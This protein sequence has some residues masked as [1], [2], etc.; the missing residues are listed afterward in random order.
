MVK[1]DN[2]NLELRVADEALAPPLEQSEAAHFPEWLLVLAKRKFFIFKFVAAGALLSVTVS[3]LLTPVY[4]ATTKVMPPQQNQSLSVTAMM[5]QLGPLAALAGQGLGVRTPSDIYVA[6]LK[7]DTVADSL[8]DRFSLMK[9]YRN[10]LRVDTRKRLAGNSLIT[11]GKEGVISIAVDDKDP[12][13]AAE[14]ANGYVDELSKLSRTLAVT[15]AAQRRVF[16][17]RETKAAMDDL[18]N[19]ELGL[20]Q[21]Q[22]KTGLILL[23]AQSRAMIETLTSLRARVAVKEVEIRAMETYAAPGNP[24]LEREKQEL[25]ALRAQEAKLEMGGGKQDIANVPIE[26][27]PT[28]GLEYL[29]KYREVKYREALF[30]LLAKQFEAAK[31]D[32]ARDTFLVQQLDKALV[33]EKK[34]WPSRALLSIAGTMLAFFI[35]LLVVFFSEKLET[36][37]KDAQF[38]SQMQLFRYYLSRRKS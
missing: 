18:A 8:I 13:R 32:E 25:A 17:E 34:S 2:A 21:T 5:S 33:P 22:E 37:Q 36:S 6:M 16:F 24:D 14:I 23:D 35:A 9:V 31:I 3:L 11:A 20:K 1:R 12:R 28:A 38:A 27:V 10:K 30:E 15:E 4:T 19:A 29:R 7:S 26:N